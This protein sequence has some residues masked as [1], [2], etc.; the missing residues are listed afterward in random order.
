MQT[1][2]ELQNVSHDSNNV[3]LTR[4]IT[5]Q[6]LCNYSLLGSVTNV[7]ETVMLL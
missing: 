3:T 5:N 7:F 4:K 1:R 6:G 2:H